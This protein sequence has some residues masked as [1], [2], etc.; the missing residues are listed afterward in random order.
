VE[1][2]DLEDK[3]EYARATR[4]KAVLVCSPMD[5]R[6]STKATST[7]ASIRI[8]ELEQ[9]NAVETFQVSHLSA[10]TV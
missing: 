2:E 9:G 5:T 8:L 6:T 4:A 1:N 3:Q 7:R 10:L